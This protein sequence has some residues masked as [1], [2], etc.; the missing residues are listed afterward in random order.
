[1]LT[2]KDLYD[3]LVAFHKS[4]EAGKVDIT[5]LRFV[6]YANKSTTSNE[7]QECSISDHKADCSDA[8]DHL[9]I[10][11]ANIKVSEEQESTKESD[12]RP[13]FKQMIEDIKT[14]KYDAI[15]TWHPDCLARNI[16]DAGKIIDL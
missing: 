16:A 13:H 3:A 9:G 10:P 8:A 1:M 5:K 2:P 12:I 4:L 15:L 7:R 14:G 6:L 11:R